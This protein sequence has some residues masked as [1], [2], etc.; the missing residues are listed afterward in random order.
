MAD[1]NRIS[2]MDALLFAINLEVAILQLRLVES[3]AKYNEL[4]NKASDTRKSHKRN[5]LSKE[6]LLVKDVLRRTLLKLL[7]EGEAAALKESVF[8]LQKSAIYD[9]Q[10][11]R[12]NEELKYKIEELSTELIKMRLESTE[13][14][15][16][17]ERNISLLKDKIKDT[18]LNTNM[19]LNYVDKWLFAR[20]ESLDLEH[21]I[22]LPPPPRV[23]FEK[24]VH[25]QVIKLYEL[26]IKERE[27]SLEYWRSRYNKDIADIKENVKLQCEKLKEAVDRR[28]ELQ[29]LYDLHEGEMRAWLT[30]KQ[31]R[32]ARLAREER[33][34][35][36]AT[37]IQA[38]WRGVMVRRILGNLDFTAVRFEC[39]KQ[40]CG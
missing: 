8:L 1:Q 36:A 22:E 7:S 4:Y 3:C 31:E 20:A 33:S 19:Q 10:L 28:T 9:V 35:V 24:R 18:L 39:D 32:S 16:N 27:A 29:K 2:K 23:D 40:L 6:R 38:W 13:N 14:V 12:S 15:D 5:K 11:R 17:C 30:F 25:E 21:R 26:Q 37:R 34:R